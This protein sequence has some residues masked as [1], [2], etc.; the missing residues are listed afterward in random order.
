MPE[1]VS[2]IS[3][4]ARIEPGEGKALAWSFAYFFCL[5][6]GYYILRP[7]RDEMGI[8]SGVANL[9]GLF[10]ATFAA[11]LALVPVFGWAAARLPRR[12]LVPWTYLFFVANIGVFYALF[13]SGAARP[14]VAAAFFVWVSVF[15]LFVVSV[16]WSL[17]ADLFTPEQAARLFGVVSAGGTS[18]ALAGTAL[19]AVLVGP[20]GAAAR[21]ADRRHDLVGVGRDRALALPRRHRGLRAALHG[22]AR[23]RVLR[24]RAH[25]RRALRRS[26]RAHG[27]LRARR[28]RGERA[29]AARAA[30]R[31]EQVRGAARRGRGAG[32]ASPA[33]ARRVRRD[34][35]RARARG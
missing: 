3:R 11:T 16:F 29:D 30:P 19:T 34:G 31:R 5:L 33:R 15:N 20:R 23:V 1:A 32:A 6:C 12:R 26:R 17:M 27:P 22:A 13:E 7:L 10:S 28:S 24:A 21:G 35:R 18:G 25:D 4:V 8:Q 9:P 14:A 2:I